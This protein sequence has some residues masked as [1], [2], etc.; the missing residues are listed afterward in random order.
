MN[1]N[2]NEDDFSKYV[3]RKLGMFS[4][5]KGLNEFLNKINNI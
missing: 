2:Y 3:N 5:Y 4:W 1:N